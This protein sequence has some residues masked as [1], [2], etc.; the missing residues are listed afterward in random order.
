[1]RLALALLAARALASPAID[2]SFKGRG[3]TDLVRQRARAAL[4][5]AYSRSSPLLLGGGAAAAALSSRKSLRAAGGSH[6]GGAPSADGDGK[7]LRSAASEG[8]LRLPAIGSR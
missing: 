2:F 1:M 5:E 8:A 4:A 6:G 7:G 3:S